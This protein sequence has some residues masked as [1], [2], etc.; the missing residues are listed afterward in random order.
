MLSYHQLA[1]VATLWPLATFHRITR[2]ARESS[3]SCDSPYTHIEI[4][5]VCGQCTW[6]VESESAMIGRI[7]VPRDLWKEIKTAPQAFIITVA[8]AATTITAT[9]TTIITTSWQ[10]RYLSQ[11]VS[12]TRYLLTLIGHITRVGHTQT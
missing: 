1:S 4:A 11:S 6:E 8:I 7:Y 3:D 12:S 9:T 2:S 5:H 10:L